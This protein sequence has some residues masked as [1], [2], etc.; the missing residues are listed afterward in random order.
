VAEKISLKAFKEMLSKLRSIKR[1]RGK[2]FK[3]NWLHGNACDLQQ[4]A[5]PTDARAGLSRRRV[6]GTVPHQHQCEGLDYEMQLI[7]LTE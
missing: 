4:R 7:R 3:R 6:F 2:F 5:L 1:H